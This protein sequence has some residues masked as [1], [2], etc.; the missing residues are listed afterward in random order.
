MNTD[1]PGGTDPDDIETEIARHREEL[2]RTVAALSDR[3]NV[4]RRAHRAIERLQRLQDSGGMIPLALAGALAIGA[5]LILR[6]KR[7]RR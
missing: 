2:G 3:L 5:V 6:G 1:N 4:P 7:A